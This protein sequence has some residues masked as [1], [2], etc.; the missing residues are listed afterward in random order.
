MTDI[1]AVSG[2]KWKGNWEPVV[3]RGSTDDDGFQY[4]HNWHLL[5]NER[6]PSAVESVTVSRV[7]LLLF[8]FTLC[9]RL[10]SDAVSGSG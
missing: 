6:S 7:I 3:Q 9:S 2:F 1:N 5:L 10:L 4:A 8:I